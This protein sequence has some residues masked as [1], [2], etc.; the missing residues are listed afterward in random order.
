MVFPAW[1]LH[2]LTGI[3]ASH[4]G[5]W[6]G[7]RCHLLVASLA[8]R[9]AGVAARHAGGRVGKGRGRAAQS[10]TQQ[11]H[12]LIQTL[13]VNVAWF[14]PIAVCPPPCMAPGS[15][16]D[17]RG[18]MIMLCMLSTQSGSGSSASNSPAAPAHQSP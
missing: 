11:L 7:V 15:D 2:W 17:P 8:F 14:N 18:T 10:L 13:R 16:D 5:S 1:T 9:P 6:L 3:T 12:S 4:R